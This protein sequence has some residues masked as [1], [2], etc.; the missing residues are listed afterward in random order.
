MKKYLKDDEE[1][2][3]N[4]KNKI[5]KEAMNKFYPHTSTNEERRKA[6]RFIL[7]ELTQIQNRQNGRKIGKRKMKIEHRRI[8]H[9]HQT[10]R[11]LHINK[12]DIFCQ[13]RSPPFNTSEK[14]TDN[15]S[16]KQ[17]GQLWK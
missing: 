7:K 15:C 3:R 11:P 6:H 4:L 13:T 8:S 1:L 14:E 5:E 2:T 17:H 12:T 9:P 10:D 16:H